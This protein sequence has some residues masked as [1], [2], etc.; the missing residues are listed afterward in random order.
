M[1]K[2]NPTLTEEEIE[3]KVPSTLENPSLTA[4]PEMGDSD[5]PP[6][7]L[8][9]GNIAGVDLEALHETGVLKYN[10]NLM[11]QAR[12]MRQNP[13]KAEKKLWD[14]VLRSRQTGFKFTR[15]KPIEN[16][17]LDFYCSELL[18]AIEADGEVH[19]QQKE[20]DKERDERLSQLG[21]KVLRLTNQEILEGIQNAQQTIKTTIKQRQK[22]LSKYSPFQGGWGVK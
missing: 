3:V 22:Q 17:I 12:L 2:V 7:P 20:K 15:Q 9:K 6:S 14:E 5:S 18:L 1:M 4:S 8:E 16:F 19:N 11:E 21:I 13:T 10:T